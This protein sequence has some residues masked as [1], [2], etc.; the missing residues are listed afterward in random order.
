MEISLSK[1]VVKIPAPDQIRKTL[2]KISEFRVHP[3]ERVLIHGSSG[4]GKTTLLHLVAGLLSPDEGQVYLGNHRWNILSDDERCQIR[5][6]KMGIIFQKLNLIDYLTASENVRLGLS[7]KTPEIK[8]V[9]AE[10]L[11]TVHLEERANDRVAV[12]S[13]GE[14]Q[15]IAVARVLAAEPDITLADEPTSSL[16]DRNAR[17]VLDS[18]LSM[19]KGKTL[20]VVS[21][22]QRIHSRFERV[23]SF[24]ELTQS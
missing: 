8:K 19:A 7:P 16:D 18:L 11:R 10:A 13:A 17:V 14:Q 15:R 22:D 23:L 9:A 12:M 1:V 6:R 5:R 3:G 21:H 4:K 24:E 20:I 2:F